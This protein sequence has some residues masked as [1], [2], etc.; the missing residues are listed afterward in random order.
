LSSLLRQ[1]GGSM[2]LAVMTTL[3]SRYT[4]QARE[5]LK[6]QMSGDRAQVISTIKGATGAAV[7]MGVDPARAQIAAM[8]N[9]YGRVAREGA[10][11]GFEKTF[12]VGALLF[13]AVA[14]LVLMLRPAP[15]A[16]PLHVDIE[17]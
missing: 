4:T 7:A 14:P 8:G 3:L 2:G 15:K 13:V 16:T 6:W 12:A 11:I 1:I 9:L 5:A 10:V 17:V